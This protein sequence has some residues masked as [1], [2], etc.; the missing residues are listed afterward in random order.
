VRE[1][2]STNVKHEQ[3]Y[4]VVIIVGMDGSTCTVRDSD[5]SL[6][7]FHKKYETTV[8]LR[9]FLTQNKNFSG[10]SC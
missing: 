4:D 1:A 3:I 10:L 5:R 8:F 7:V 6:I 9:C 2:Y